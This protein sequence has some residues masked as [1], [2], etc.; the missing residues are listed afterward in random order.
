MRL[1]W[2]VEQGTHRG[3]AEGVVLQVGCRVQGFSGEASTA[4][5][6]RCICPRR[7]VQVPRGPDWAEDVGTSCNSA[8]TVQGLGALSSP[9]PQRESGAVH[10]GERRPVS[11]QS[12]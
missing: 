6:T 4:V 5:R 9:G 10:F 11:F 3:A 2:V 8:G 12:C 7:N 1:P